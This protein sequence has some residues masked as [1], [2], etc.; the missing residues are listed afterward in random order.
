MF[1]IPDFMEIQTPRALPNCPE[2]WRDNS[3]S[4]GNFS[5]GEGRLFRYAPACFH[6]GA[7][8]SFPPIQQ[9]MGNTKAPTWKKRWEQCFIFQIAWKAK[10]HGLFQTAR[11]NGGT[12]WE[13]RKIFLPA[14]ADSP[15]IHR[16][17]FAE[18]RPFLLLNPE[19]DGNTKL[20][21]LLQKV[22][23]VFTIAESAEEAGRKENW[24]EIGRSILHFAT[25]V[26]KEKAKNACHRL[27]SE[28]HF[29]S[30]R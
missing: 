19:W 17:I 12:I 21:L 30:R 3:E 10:P 13:A 9:G 27:P 7:A 23:V 25:T 1:Y 26:G 6:R 11:G 18:G 5:P 14:R 2:R 15:V 22:G 16:R 20:P 8:T 28:R 29:R 4:A 24:K